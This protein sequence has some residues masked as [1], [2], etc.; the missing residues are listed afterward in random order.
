VPHERPSGCLL[1]CESP[2]ETTTLLACILLG[3]QMHQSEKTISPVQWRWQALGGCCEHFGSLQGSLFF[4]ARPDHHVWYLGGRSSISVC[5]SGLTISA[6]SFVLV[7]ADF[8]V[9]TF[10]RKNSWVNCVCSCLRA[11]ETSKLA[12]IHPSAIARTDMS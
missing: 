8:F 1:S 10:G 3:L 7:G 4:I 5:V 12:G 11:L 6:V 2:E 9:L